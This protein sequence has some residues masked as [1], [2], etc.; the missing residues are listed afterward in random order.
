MD[1]MTRPENQSSEE[2]EAWYEQGLTHYN[3]QEW[4][5]AYESFQQAEITLLN[6]LGAFLKAENRPEA[7]SEYFKSARRATNRTLRLAPPGSHWIRNFFGITGVIALI[8]GIVSIL[9]FPNIQFLI[10]LI[11]V[12]SNR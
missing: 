8:C 12:K 9:L 1:A 2:Y 4:K 6:E 5:E 10:A 11:T 3:R 7:A